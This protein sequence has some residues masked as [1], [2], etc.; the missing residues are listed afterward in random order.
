MD[1]ALCD[2][3]SGV[4]K[5]AGDGQLGETHIASYAGEGVP[6]DVGRDV[7]Q[8]SGQAKPLED[9]D[10][11][12]EVTVADLAREDVGVFGVARLLGSAA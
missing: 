6:Q 3:S 10:N 1:V 4:T 7:L 8:L 2:A 11:A 12:N 5:E 9:A